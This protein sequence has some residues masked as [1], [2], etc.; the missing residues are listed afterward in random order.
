[1]MFSDTRFDMVSY[2]HSPVTFFWDMVSR[3]RHTATSFFRKITL[4]WPD[5]GSLFCLLLP[6][7]ITPG[8]NGTVYHVHDWLLKEA[9]S[10]R[11]RKPQYT[12][13]LPIFDFPHPTFLTFLWIPMNT[14]NFYNILVTWQVTQSLSF[15][16]KTHK[17]NHS[18]LS[19]IV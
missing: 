9:F 19:S 8:T 16:V 4:G 10:P 3:D 6:P 12:L 14:C 7:Q 1:M 15:P 5:G 18:Q 11:K 17:I 13:P 2:I